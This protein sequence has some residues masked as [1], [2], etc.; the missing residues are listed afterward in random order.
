MFMR[1]SSKIRDSRTRQSSAQSDSSSDSAST[2]SRTASA[3]FDRGT[4]HRFT[5]SNLLLSLSV[6]GRSIRQVSIISITTFYNPAPL[7]PGPPF[8]EQR[9]AC[10]P[11]S[12]SKGQEVRLLVRCCR[13]TEISLVRDATKG[14]LRTDIATEDLVLHAQGQGLRTV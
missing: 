7:C 6:F 8:Y 12:T 2:R 14:N 4:A 10:P 9:S 1:A 11:E 13:L 3:S 5:Q